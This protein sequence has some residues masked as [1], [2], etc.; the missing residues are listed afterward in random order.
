MQLHRL[1]IGSASEIPSIS[2]NGVRTRIEANEVESMAMKMTRFPTKPSQSEADKQL[3]D[4]DRVIKRLQ[5]APFSP[6]NEE[7]LED[8]VDAA[9]VIVSRY[10]TCVSL[11]QDAWAHCCSEDLKIAIVSVVADEYEDLVD[12]VAKELFIES[13]YVVKIEDQLLSGE[14]QESV[15]G[16]R[17][18]IRQRVVRY[19][20]LCGRRNRLM[21]VSDDRVKE[22]AVECLPH[23][24]W[25]KMTLEKYE[26]SLDQMFV[27]AARIEISLKEISERGGPQPLGVMAAEDDDMSSVHGGH[28][29]F[30]PCSSCSS[31]KHKQKDCPYREYRCHKCGN[32]GHI[33]KA[34]K[35]IVEKDGKGRVTMR[36][37]PT[38]A[39]A[40]VKF[41]KDKTT[42]DRVMTAEE[43]LANLRGMLE[44]K[45]LKAKQVREAKQVARPNKRRTRSDVPVK[46]VEAEDIETESEEESDVEVAWVETFAEAVETAEAMVVD[47]PTNVKIPCKIAGVRLEAI[48]DTGAAHC[49][50]G[51][52]IAKKAR[53]KSAGVKKSFRGLGRRDGVK[54]EPVEV[55]VGDRIAVVEL[56]VVDDVDFPLLLGV[57][58]LRQLDVVVD[59]TDMRVRCRES[60]EII[61]LSWE[62]HEAIVNK[63]GRGGDTVSGVDESKT[64][65]QLLE[66]AKGVFDELT[67]HLEDVE[68]GPKDKM[69]R[70][71][72][73]Y[74][75][76]WL[77]PR[78]GK[79]NVMKASFVVEGRPIKQK[80]RYISPELQAELDKQ[81]NEMLDKKVIRPSKS[82]WGSVPVFVKKKTGEYRLC[83]DYRQL[84]SRMKADSYPLPLIWENLQRSAQHRLYICLDC[85][86]GFWNVPL[87]ELS[88]EYTAIVTNRGSFEFNVLPFGIK[89][90]PS[91]YQRAMDI[92]LGD[93]YAQGVLCYVDDIVIYA[94]DE[95]TIFHLLEWVLNQCCKSGLYLKLKKS[96]LFKSEVTLLGHIVSVSG[97]RPH[98]KKIE[99]VQKAVAPRNKSEVRTFLGAAS[100]LRKFVPHFSRI[101]APIVNLTKKDVH[102]VWGE[103][104]AEAFQEI[105]DMLSEHIMLSAPM[106]GA[107]PVVVTDASDTG[108]GAALLQLKDKEVYVLEFASKTLSS[109]ERKWSVQER[110]LYAIKWAVD[111]FR[112]YVKGTMFYVVTDHQSLQWLNAASNG[113]VQRWALYLQQYNVK[114]IHLAGEYN[115]L[116][117]W[118]SRST[119]DEPNGDEVIDTIAVPTFAVE[120]ATQDPWLPSEEDLRLACEDAP[121]EELRD[122]VKGDDG[123]LYGARSSLLY[124][125]PSLREPFLYWFHA[126]RYGGHSVPNKTFRRMKKWVWWPTLRK[127]IEAYVKSCLLCQRRIRSPKKTLTGV[128]ERPL[129]FQL[130]SLD[131]VGP[132]IWKG[133]EVHYLVV[134]DHH[135]RFVLAFPTGTPENAPT[136]DLFK[137]RWCFVFGAP[138]VVLTDRGVAFRGPPFTKYVTDDLGAYHMFS[139]PYYPRGNGINEACHLSLESALQAS[140]NLEVNDFKVAL[141]DAVYVHNT[142]PHVATG[143]SPF[144]CLFGQEMCLPGWQVFHLP[145]A[146]DTRRAKQREERFQALVRASLVTQ[147]VKLSPIDKGFH[148][149]DLVVFRLSDYERRLETLERNSSYD[150]KWSLPHKIKKIV[151]N[152]LQVVPIGAGEA[153]SVRQVPVAEVMK[154]EADVPKSLL[155]MTMDQLKLLKP[156]R[157]WQRPK[158]SIGRALAWRDLIP[159]VPSQRLKRLRPG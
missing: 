49:L 26:G 135:S 136:M 12:Q 104:Q 57:D 35:S 76:C 87:E 24:V 18:W 150:L 126:S 159:N 8:W 115:V 125:P 119:Q 134:I 99:A 68:G 78:G 58:A 52:A 3:D 148:V 50:C 73:K 154:L 19:H 55:K 13:R 113:K 108:I 9:A 81:I 69:W 11:F 127:D 138:D 22:T 132:R 29:R 66:E 129:P 139:S 94:N 1:S 60:N 42:R 155:P 59:P 140:S 30:N 43:I 114:I 141:Q 27:K 149:D 34:C 70:L 44:G 38:T 118:L 77:R 123:L 56:Y 36:Y 4:R 33:K 106:D 7:E 133:V 2:S 71:F 83:L 122:T 130:V 5:L 85:N 157:P 90:S 152:V 39:G 97:I 109:A 158:D 120:E 61:A 151:G 72:K 25:R 102:F 80:L 128:L 40:T 153:A 111:K 131:H 121:K 107:Q 6:M 144:D 117:D 16:A 98:P 23:G 84:N 67:K 89:N 20:R 112:D 103:E 74:K 63:T 37:T 31:S 32:I 142:T 17:R 93:K 28:N 82:P 21:S 47:A 110:E 146:E 143:A 88:K 147:K 116:S 100:Y 96:E 62:E 91:E 14:K 101:V 137:Q 41:R 95:E 53:V 145:P 75:A 124:V 10:R 65:E 54:S 64:D 48:A 79:V 51:T 45:S 86:W 156:R 105:K 46:M 92:I 15:F